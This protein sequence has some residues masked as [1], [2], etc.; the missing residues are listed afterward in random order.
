[1]K[2][3][4]S[5]LGGRWFSEVINAAVKVKALKTSC[6]Q[7]AAD[8]VPCLYRRG[9]RPALQA[10]LW[11]AL[12]LVSLGASGLAEGQQGSG[13]NIFITGH[14]I[15]A[16][17]GQ[18][19]FDKVV[20][21]YLRDGDPISS[22]EIAVIG[23]GVS[24]ALNAPF[25]GVGVPSCSYCEYDWS[26]EAK[27]VDYDI[28]T[29][30]YNTDD[31]INGTVQWCDVLSK[32][33]LVILSYGDGIPP[34]L[35]GSFWAWPDN[36]MGMNTGDLSDS[37]VAE[38]FTKRGDIVCAFNSGMDLLV[39]GG[40]DSPDYY[41]FLAPS[42][43]SPPL[44]QAPVSYNM[45]VAYTLDLAV[46]YWVSPTIAGCQDPVFHERPCGVAGDSTGSCCWQYQGA[47]LH[48]CSFCRWMW[49]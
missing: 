36:P 13:G 20:M 34:G 28:N 29:T 15:F 45:G 26:A 39:L 23:S 35:A 9:R 11:V 43:M 19:G 7:L 14:P 6:F 18:N 12:F 41:S 8:I 49:E 31:L 42:A 17:G 37:G 47:A 32:D 38:I 16:R 21:D 46:G 27:A 48:F 25:S 33:C 4:Q 30:Y 3:L 1:M 22:Y 5:I 24:S 44:F 10:A 40:G 2:K